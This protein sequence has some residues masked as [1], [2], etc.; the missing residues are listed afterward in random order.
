MVVT[1]RTFAVR[2]LA[3]STIEFSGT[4]MLAA[5]SGISV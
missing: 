4:S 2:L 3:V 1:N 5:G